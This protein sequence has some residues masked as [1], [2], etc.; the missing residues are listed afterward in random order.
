MRE[1]DDIKYKS[2][3]ISVEEVDKG[4][5]EDKKFH[6][7]TKDNK[8]LLL[9]ICDVSQYEKKK[10]EFEIIKDLNKRSLN[11]SDQKSVV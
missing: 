3:W 9:R 4:W 1:Y 10:K 2:E 7:R 11:M 5:S 6:I 8:N